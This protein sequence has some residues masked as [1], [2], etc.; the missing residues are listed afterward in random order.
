MF[1]TVI[2]QTA[3][4]I[5]LSRYQS[6]HGTLR[7][8]RGARQPLPEQESGIADILAAWQ[9]E[10]R[11][12]RIILALPPAQ[13]SLRELAIALA[14]RKKGR[15]ILPLEL[16]GEM[17][18]ADEEPVFDALPLAENGTVAIWS[19]RTT[20]AAALKL[21]AD[22][23]FDPEIVSS[24]LFS[25]QRLLPD[26]P[27]GVTAITDGEGLAVF[28]DGRP[29]FFRALP[30]IGPQPLD[31]T[32][33]ALELGKNVS[34]AEVYSIGTFACDSTRPVIP[35]PANAGL[36]AAFGTDTSA[37]A[38]LASHY[39]L[40]KDL[41]AGDPVN[42]RRGPLRFTKVHDRLRRKLR[43][44]WSLLAILVLLL[45]AEAGVRYALVR[46][47]V[48][49]LNNSINKIYREVFPNRARAV[50]EVAELKAEIKRLGAGD[51]AGLLD[52]L[53]ALA[54]A[55][56]DAP[57]ELYEIDYD[58][59]QVSGKG[60]DR[61]AQGVSDFKAKAASRFS[62]FEVSEIK[63]RP[64]GTVSFAFRGRLK[65]DGQ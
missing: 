7:L 5:I 3:T 46:K 40:A 41:V 6:G 18:A 62:A 63:S 48:V 31:A 35:L 23:G 36:T 64:D 11:E 15:E 47:D 21:F 45:F 20:L 16:K 50:D 8:L 38:D 37:A 60:Y 12:D 43:L 65:E 10:C 54:E 2:Q 39:A 52:V 17:A 9:T 14:D 61:S 27:E 59:G 22:A 57:H 34:V 42:L 44:T 24:A 25:W 53:N 19:K 1:I 33:A 32:L 28:R 58:G 13:F 30:Q 4:E 55:K 56:G 29:L 49:S 51:A 26:N